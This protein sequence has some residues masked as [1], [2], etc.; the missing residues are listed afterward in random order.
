MYR[1]FIAL[2]IFA[3]ISFIAFSQTVGIGT[4][5][6]DQ[7]AQ[8]HINS[9][10]KG[11]LVPRMTAADR[12]SIIQPATGLIVYQTDGSQGFYYNS[13][14]PVSPAWLLLINSA[15]AGTNGSILYSTGAGA[16]F[17]DT[18]TP[19]F[20]LKSNGIAAPTWSLLGQTAQTVYGTAT[21]TVT[22]T[23]PSTLIPGL[24]QSVNVPA[25]A[26]VYIATN[27]GLSTT[28]TFANGYSLVDIII[29]V[30]GVQLSNSGLMRR[31]ATNTPSL[32]G[33]FSDW[34]NA[35]VLPLPPGPHTIQVNA[36]GINIGIGS[37]ANVSGNNFSNL[38]GNLTV[39]LLKQ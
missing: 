15:T 5:T 22:P 8:L 29:L 30:D 3:F 1:H 17:T 26:L 12:A 13:G 11:L 19:G 23:T 35:M 20:F 36:A 9:T 31:V 18:G 38:Q 27:G 37:N 2:V 6:P 16:A 32:L 33:L 4:T 25:N 10:D 7:S 34:S 24:T 14:T 39:V 28:S 21:L